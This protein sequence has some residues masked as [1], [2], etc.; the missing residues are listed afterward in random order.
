MYVHEFYYRLWFVINFVIQQT[1]QI[2]IDL[3]LLEVLK[4][5][6]AG[7]PMNESIKWTNFTH[8]EIASG[9]QS[10]GFTVSLPLVAKL[11]KKH[12][13]VKIKAQKKQTIGINMKIVFDEYLPKWNYRAVP[14]PEPQ[15][16]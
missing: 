7:D 5:H 13:Y 15:P 16:E 14:Q 8:K 1:T 9:L 10:A 3:A 2:G 4:N 11:F 6:T 12:G